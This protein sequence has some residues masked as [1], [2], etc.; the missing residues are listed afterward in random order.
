M[1]ERFKGL[2]YKYM[3][4]W[5]PVE[6]YSVCEMAMKGGEPNSIDCLLCTCESFVIHSELL[7]VIAQSNGTGDVKLSKALSDE[8]R[9]YDL[10]RLGF[11]IMAAKLKPGYTKKA[12][13]AWSDK[14]E[15]IIEKL[16]EVEVH[17]Q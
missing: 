8:R 11:F 17:G 3:C 2:S 5:Q 15:E 1:S 14:V 13:E 6:A 7:W 9:Q 16:K 10:T 12:E 4:K